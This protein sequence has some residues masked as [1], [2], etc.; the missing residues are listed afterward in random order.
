MLLV[1]NVKTRDADPNRYN[2]FTVNLTD[3]SHSPR[4]PT[5]LEGEPRLTP[6]GNKIV[7]EETAPVFLPS[8]TLLG[9][10]SVGR[11]HV[12]DVATGTKLGQ[13]AIPLR[14]AGSLTGIRPQ[15]D[16]AYFLSGVAPDNDQALASVSLANFALLKEVTVPPVVFMALF[17]DP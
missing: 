2:L 11:L 12:Y 10:Q 3:Q 5:G 16:K 7:F 6:L 9:S 14:G 1:E 15:G 8:G 13:L 17:E 4:I